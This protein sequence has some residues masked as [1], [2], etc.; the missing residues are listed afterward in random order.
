MAFENDRTEI[1]KPHTIDRDRGIILRDVT[2]FIPDMQPR[3]T[4][5]WG[6]HTIHFGGARTTEDIAD[7]KT[8]NIAWTITY[9]KV[10]HEFEY[11]KNQIFQVISE[12][13]DTYGDFFRREN[14]QD[15]TVNF[16]DNVFENDM[17]EHW[18]E[19]RA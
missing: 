5:E 16:D 1:S 6:D 19:E 17:P 12:A 9:I 2:P 8:Y 14:V 13:L 3:F 15:V 18:M 7:T 11:D 10:P 4:L